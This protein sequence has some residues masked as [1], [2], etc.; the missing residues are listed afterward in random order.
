MPAI[1]VTDVPLARA[2]S[3]SDWGSLVAMVPS[4]L[5]L[6]SLRSATRQG[7]ELIANGSNRR[8]FRE[9]IH[10]TQA[11]LNEAAIPL[12][13]SEKRDG[14]TLLAPQ[15][16]KLRRRRWMGQLALELYFAQLFRSDWAV[17]DLSPSRLGVDG[18]G[19]AVW[20]PRPLYVRWD[21]DFLCGLRDVYAGF[22]LDDE[23]R[24]GAGV[25]RLGLGDS[26]S[27][28]ARHLGDGNQRSVRFDPTGLELTL[29]EIAS[30]RGPKSGPLHP[31]FVAFGLYATFLHEL[32]HSYDLAFD[33]RSAF[34]RS[35][36]GEP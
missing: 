16:L 5:E 11:T 1:P 24:F 31:N 36:R 6:V 32:L 17:L 12:I 8:R 15:D 28:L 27:I 19:D 14:A 9:R 3:S 7:L 34:M 22:F 4:A 29:D 21:A 10:A 18:A 23:S 26:G 20:R 35:H 13:V 30:K 2:S 25:R 33:V